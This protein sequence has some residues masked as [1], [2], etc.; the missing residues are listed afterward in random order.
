MSDSSKCHTK[1]KQDNSLY[2]GDERW[3]ELCYTPKFQ[4]W[5]TRPACTHQLRRFDLTLITFFII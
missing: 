5:K 4:K 1:I 3:V 2:Y